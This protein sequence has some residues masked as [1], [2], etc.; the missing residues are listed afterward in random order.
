MRYRAQPD[1]AIDAHACGLCLHPENPECFGAIKKIFKTTPPFL[2]PGAIFGSDGLISLHRQARDCMPIAN[3]VP[4]IHMI[5]GILQ[6][7]LAYIGCLIQGFESIRNFKVGIDLNAEGGTPL[8]LNT[9]DCA[10]GNADTSLASLMDAMWPIEPLLQLI[11]PSPASLESTS[12]EL[13]LSGGSSGDDP[14]QPIID[15]HDKLQEIV[16]SLP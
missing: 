6:L 13:S 2:D 4:W 10:K 5:K 14:L 1:V 15:F 11:S 7:I 3:P 12:A 16:E 9:L 8:L